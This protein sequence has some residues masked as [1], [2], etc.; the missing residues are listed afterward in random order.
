MGLVESVAVITAVLVPAGPLGVPVIAP[1]AL[2]ES[3]A[4]RPV[5]VKVYGLVPPFAATVVAVYTAPTIPPGNDV[6]VIASGV[7]IVMDRL[8]VAVRWVGL[9]ESVTVIAAVLVPAALGV[10]VI[11]PVALIESPAG[12]PVAVNVYGAVPPFA[13]TVGA[14]YATPTTPA[15]SEVVVNPSGVTI[16]IGRFAVAVEW[17]GVFESVTV[18]TAVLVPAALGVPVIRPAVLIESPAG[19]PVAVKVKGATPP[20]ARTSVLY[21]V[22]TVPLVSE[23]VVM[24]TPATTVI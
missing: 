1:A 18:M 9:V 22:P 6:V 23:A 11:T 10:P 3:P 21:A 2:I 4:G 12:K 14:V 16:V 24:V 8:A 20:L 17:V 13:P 15:G 7:T 5:A 19:K